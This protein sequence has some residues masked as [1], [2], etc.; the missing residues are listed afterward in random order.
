MQRLLPLLC[1]LIVLA[2]ACSAGATTTLMQQLP[3]STPYLCLNCHNVANPTSLTA[4]LNSFGTA[5]KDNGDRWDRTLALQRS[6][7]DNCTNGFE[8]GDEDGDG[9]A[10]TGVTQERSNP[11]QGDCSLQI[12]PQAWSNLKA[13][14]R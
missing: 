7:T 4:G 3:V 8:V 6:D 14:F 9:R 10:D 2:S 1:G 13:L 12:T 11:G 5:F